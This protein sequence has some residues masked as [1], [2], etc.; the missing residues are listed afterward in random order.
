[1][2]QSNNPR[3]GRG[4]SGRRPNVPSRSYNF[5][6]N[7]PEGRVR[8]NASQVYEKYLQLARDAQSAGDRVLGES[9]MQHAEHY[10]RI[11]NE[12]A[13]PGSRSQPQREGRAAERP[14]ERERAAGSLNEETRG[15]DSGDRTPLPARARFEDRRSQARSGDPRYAEAQRGASDGGREEEAPAPE[16]TADEAVKTVKA[17]EA[18]AVEAP[19]KPEA[20]KPARRTRRSP[21]RRTTAKSK[22]DS[23]KSDGDAGE[24][25][26]GLLKMLGE[27]PRANGNGTP[28]AETSAE[29]TAE[30]PEEEAE[31]KPVKP[32]RRR[33]TKGASEAPANVD[34]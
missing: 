18:E 21:T 14:E 32:R 34:A 16:P 15:S 2:R 26:A 17:D 1:M 6:S 10:Y 11:V 33:T 5:E 3:R 12:S 27:A 29:A 4:R 22:S 28:T 25:D 19:G 13:D 20:E 24:E 9:F 23:A 7:G 30:R 31:A 8:G